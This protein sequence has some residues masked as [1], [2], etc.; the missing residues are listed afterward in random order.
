MKK[1]GNV[2]ISFATEPLF[3]VNKKKGSVT[4]RLEGELNVPSIELP[5]V[6]GDR[7]YRFNQHKTILAIGIATCSPDDEFDANR[8]KRIALAKAENEAYNLAKKYLSAY[9]KFLKDDI[10]AIEN[11]YDKAGR[12]VKHNKEYIQGLS[13][14]NNPNYKEVILPPQR[15]TTAKEE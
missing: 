9:L 2:K 15:G 5:I 6:E 3:F 12:A 1:N 8:G 11:F 7:P 4:C 10:N 14:K 13:D